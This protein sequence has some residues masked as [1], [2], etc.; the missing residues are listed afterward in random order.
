MAKGKVA[1]CETGFTHT[2]VSTWRKNSFGVLLIQKLA[3]LAVLMGGGEEA[4]KKFPP[5]KGG[6]QKVLW[7]G[8]QF[9]GPEILPF[10]RP[11][12]CNSVP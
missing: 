8:Q 1:T 3:V 2:V 11:P 10:C 6:A 5:F 12:P 7:G 4:Q 9:F